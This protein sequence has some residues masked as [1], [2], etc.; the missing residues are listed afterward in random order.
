M[1]GFCSLELQA[2]SHT[3]D[4]DIAAD[5]EAGLQ[6]KRSGP[7]RQGGLRTYL[8]M[9]TWVLPGTVYDAASETSHR[10]Q[11]WMDPL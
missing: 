2:N 8:G 10:R 5:D 9:Y 3:V 1:D 6:E 11:V 7:C 4:M